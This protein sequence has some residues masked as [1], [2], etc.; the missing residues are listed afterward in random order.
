MKRT[1]LLV[2]GLLLV[3]S[4]I[5]PFGSAHAQTFRLD[6]SASQVLGGPVAMKWESFVPRP[7]H[8]D[9]LSGVITV[10]VRLDVSEWKG[11][12]VRIYHTLPAHPSG[13]FT[14]RWTTHGRLLPGTMRDGERALVYSGQLQTDV[15]EDTFRILVQTDSGRLSREERLEFGFEID[16]ETP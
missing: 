15:M 2:H 11:R 5:V 10:V 7:G 6:D 8:G 9:A 4:M 14:V 1:M 12:T 16:V 3:G 13:P